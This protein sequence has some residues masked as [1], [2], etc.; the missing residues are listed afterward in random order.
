MRTDVGKIGDH[1]GKIGD[2]E[3]KIP[4]EGLGDG[5]G[6]RLGHDAHDE[7]ADQVVSVGGSGGGGGSDYVK[8]L[9]HDVYG[10]GGR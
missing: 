5:D 1:E 4:E 3:G 9:V 2:H 8:G 7:E 6:G 10:P